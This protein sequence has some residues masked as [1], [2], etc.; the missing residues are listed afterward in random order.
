METTSSI[1]AVKKGI[2]LSLGIILTGIG[3]I[4]IFLPILPTTIFLILASICFM[5]SS[6][7]MNDWLVN[8]KYLGQYIKAYRNNTGMTVKSKITSIVMLWI[9]ISISGL[10]FTDSTPV[11]LLLLL[12]AAGVTIHLITIKTANSVS[13]KKSKKLKEDF[14]E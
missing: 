8:H 13:V 3:I 2:L 4:G 12:I 14:N 6:K 11:R 5:K 7:R 9:S 1:Q 10:Y